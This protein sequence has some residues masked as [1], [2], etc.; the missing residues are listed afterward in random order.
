VVLTTTNT[1]CKT[2]QKVFQ[3]MVSKKVRDCSFSSHNH[4][5]LSLILVDLVYV[6]YGTKHLV[7]LR[8]GL[9]STDMAR[10]LPVHDQPRKMLLMN[11]NMK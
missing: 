9:D 4:D 10:S 1:D 6:Q 11:L 3:F 5:Q 7:D 2:I 8:A